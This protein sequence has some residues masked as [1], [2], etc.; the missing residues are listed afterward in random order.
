MSL[1][2]VVK[3]FEE[4]GKHINTIIDNAPKRE[5]NILAAALVA[6]AILAF[7]QTLVEIEIDRK[8]SK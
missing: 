7:A 1:H 5:R 2:D 4:R 6:G 3:S 8:E